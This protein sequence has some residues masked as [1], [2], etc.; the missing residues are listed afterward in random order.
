M[1]S[2][3]CTAE[4][5]GKN[6]GHPADLGVQNENTPS[7]GALCHLPTIFKL[8]YACFSLPKSETLK[9]GL[10]PSPYYLHLAEN[11]GYQCFLIILISQELQEQAPRAHRELQRWLTA[12]T[13][14]LSSTH[15]ALDPSS[16]AHPRVQAHVGKSQTDRGCCVLHQEHLFWH[17]GP[18]PLSRSCCNVSFTTAQPRCATSTSSPGCQPE[19]T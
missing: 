17:L 5:L 18:S 7:T 8:L 9:Y 13:K 3:C 2:E 10:D 14:S 15:S 12:H 19:V 1:A 11:A 4:K 6:L 16:A